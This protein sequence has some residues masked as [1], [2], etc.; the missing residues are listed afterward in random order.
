MLEILQQVVIIFVTDLTRS[1]K[2]QFELVDYIKPKKKNLKSLKNT[3][4]ELSENNPYSQ[5][6]MTVIGGVNPLERD[7]MQM[8]QREGIGLAKKEVKYHGRIKKYHKHA[9]INY[10]ARLLK[11]GFSI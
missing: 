2:D 9:E 5:F 3:W 10:A 7:L 1:T 11:S 8:R 4:L 6:L